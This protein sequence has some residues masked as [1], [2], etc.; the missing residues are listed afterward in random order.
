MFSGLLYDRWSSL[1]GHIF[2]AEYNQQPAP[3]HKYTF[4]FILGKCVYF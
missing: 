2:P 1:I 4:G 3:G